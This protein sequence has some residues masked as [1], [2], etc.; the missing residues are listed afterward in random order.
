MKLNDKVAIVTGGA[1]GIGRAIAERYVTEGA[2]VFIAD[3]QI[4][5]AQDAA[6]AIGER[7]EAVE[8][9]VSDLA[10]INR[11]VA[12]VATR[13]GAIDVL[14]NNAAVFDLAPIV[15]VTEKSFD[16]IFTV[17]VKGLFFTL[18]AVARHMIGRGR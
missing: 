10:S 14:V 6:E 9:N 11:M 4:D 17:N 2:R 13:A 18:Q 16:K 8:V 15:E 12:Q 5:L 7:A 3:L 1:R